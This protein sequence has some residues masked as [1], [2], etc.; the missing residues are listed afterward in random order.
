MERKL[1]LMDLENARLKRETLNRENRWGNSIQQE[2]D[3]DEISKSELKNSQNHIV[4][5]TT[6]P[7]SP[8][9]SSSNTTSSFRETPSKILATC[10]KCKLSIEN[11]SS[12]QFRGETYHVKCFTCTTCSKPLNTSSKIMINES[13]NPIC[14]FC[15]EKT[16]P[17]CFGCKN[18]IFEGR[19]VSTLG[20]KYH[21]QCICC[22]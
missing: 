16:L 13:E 4:Q 6:K 7:P 12:I 10:F 17:T 2:K 8:V 15:H 3:A 1:K 9:T 18:K 5:K 22:Y 11:E 14:S 21:D 20:R 19:I